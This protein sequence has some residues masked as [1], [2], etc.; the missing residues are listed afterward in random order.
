MTPERPAATVSRMSATPLSPTHPASVPAQRRRAGA[1]AIIGSLLA[2]VLTLPFA[3]AFFSAYPG[4]DVPPFWR[5]PFLPTLRPLLTFAPPV[6]VYNLYG[7][8][9]ELVYLLFLPATV[10]LHRLH[11]GNSGRLERWG[12]ALL[13]GG[14]VLTFIGVAGDYWANGLTF[15]LS[16][17]GLLVL[18][19]GTTLYGLVL[20]RS[21]VLPRRVSWLFLA[22]LPGVFVGSWL[23]GHIPSGP[24]LP[25]A[26][27]WLALGAALWRGASARLE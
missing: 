2:L 3:S 24:T 22:C 7:R 4:D 1:A 15:V 10:V 14:L 6:A 8:V 12:F 18:A 9:Y 21:G 20:W 25:F 19:A 27:A 26:L 11:Q 5:A 17:L 23:T 13:I 16:L